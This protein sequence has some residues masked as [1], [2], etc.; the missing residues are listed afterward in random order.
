[1]CTVLLCGGGMA[2]SLSRGGRNY[3][4]VD[5]GRWTMDDGVPPKKQQQHGRGS[6][7]ITPVVLA[8]RQGRD[9]KQ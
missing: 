2:L 5:D 8:R 7:T 3:L 9:G 1:M 6:N 4:L